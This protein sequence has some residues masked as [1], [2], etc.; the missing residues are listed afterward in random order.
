MAN[1]LA[2]VM[3]D[4]MSKKNGKLKRNTDSIRMETK[5]NLDQK[6]E[7]MISSVIHSNNKTMDTTNASSAPVFKGKKV[8]LQDLVKNT[9]EKESKSMEKPMQQ[10]KNEIEKNEDQQVKNPYEKAAVT[11]S[12][13]ANPGK[14]VSAIS[15]KALGK[16]TGG[17]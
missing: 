12:V 6:E 1:P 9:S 4:Q 3:M 7:A 14:G 17:K 5:T 2:R 16:G 11:S 15:L 13:V 8:Q 10:S